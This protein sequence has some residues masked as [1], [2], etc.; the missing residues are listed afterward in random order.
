MAISTDPQTSLARRWFKPL[1]QL[2]ND[3]RSRYRC[4]SFARSL[5]TFHK[6]ANPGTGIK[7]AT[8]PRTLSGAARECEVDFACYRRDL[9]P[10]GLWGGDGLSWIPDEPSS[11]FNEPYQLGLDHQSV[12]RSRRIWLRTRLPGHHRDYR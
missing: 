5:S 11:R 6:S 9:D 3:Y 12:C 4:G 8:R 2:A 10:R 7:K 1:S